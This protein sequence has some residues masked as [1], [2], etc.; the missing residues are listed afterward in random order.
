MLTRPIALR[1]TPE[2]ADRTVQTELLPCG[3]KDDDENVSG[4]DGE[5]RSREL[6]PEKPRGNR[7]RAGR[8]GRFVTGIVLRGEHGEERFR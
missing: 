3:I 2:G 5:E 1:T 7:F 8:D 4:D 6:E